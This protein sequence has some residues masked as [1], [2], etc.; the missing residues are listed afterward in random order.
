MPAR[1][2][3][4][5]ERPAAAAAPPP[6]S[7]FAQAAGLP[8]TDRAAGWGSRLP[9][10]AG[11]GRAKLGEPLLNARVEEGGLSRSQKPLASPAVPRHRC[12]EGRPAPA[13]V[14]AAAGRGSEEP[15]ERSGDHL[16]KCMG[17]LSVALSG[18]APLPNSR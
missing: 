3:G 2:G 7:P 5:Q 10:S 14:K 17:Y 9:T 8:P 13:S 11:L 4:T 1:T 18:K 16:G 15:G 6:R 12:K